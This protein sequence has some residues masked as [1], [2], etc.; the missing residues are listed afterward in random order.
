MAYTTYTR[1]VSVSSDKPI[2]IIAAVFTILGFIFLIIGLR[3]YSDSKALKERCTGSVQA[4]VTSINSRRSTTGSKGKRRTT[5][6]Y[7]PEFSY[8]VDGNVYIVSSNVYS[9]ICKVKQGDVVDLKYNPDN[10]NEFYYADNS[11][12]KI[13]VIVFT[14]LGGVFAFIGIAFII[15][16]VKS[17]KGRD[18]S[19][20]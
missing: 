4:T 16:G 14:V 19:Q 17:K 1:R 18:I 5:T 7:S 20:M 2:K 11:P 10:P 13:L 8:T 3:F 6:V 9:S 12:T 15:G